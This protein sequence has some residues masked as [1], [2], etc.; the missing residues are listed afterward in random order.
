MGF[1]L[2]IFKCVTMFSIETRRQVINIRKRV[3]CVRL[4][5]R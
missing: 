5:F 2:Y 1:N 4:R 3:I